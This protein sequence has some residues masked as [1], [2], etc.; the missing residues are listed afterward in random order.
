MLRVIGRDRPEDHAR[1]GTIRAHASPSPTSST[2][3]VASWI[4][5]HDRDAVLA[6]FRAERVPVAP[7]NDLAELTRDPH[8]R[9][10]ESLATFPDPALGARHAGRPDPEAE[11]L[12]G[13]P[14]HPGPALSA[15]TDEVLRDWLALAADEIARLRAAKAI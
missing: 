9:A 11:R 15:H 6:A 4:A 8:V 10:R 1:Y 14:R 2:A 7:V 5:G 13:P 12:A 3:L